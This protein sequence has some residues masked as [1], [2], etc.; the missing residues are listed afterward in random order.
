MVEVS[1]VEKGV[2][3]WTVDKGFSYTHVLLPL[4]ECEKLIT[5]C[6]NGAE[7]I[8][9]Q[10]S[11]TPEEITRNRITA[12]GR[13]YNELSRIPKR[14]KFTISGANLKQLKLQQNKLREIKDLM[15]DLTIIK[16]D[17]VNEKSYTSIDENKFEL[18]LGVLIDV[19]SDIKFP[20]KH[21]IFRADEDDDIDAIIKDIVEG[22]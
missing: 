10:L 22:G 9:E 1:S 12:I 13:V 6:Q 5:I 8:E 15:K 16:V 4:I 18:C 19:L 21:L 11:L 17:Q 2:I 14:V 20:L 3:P 7:T